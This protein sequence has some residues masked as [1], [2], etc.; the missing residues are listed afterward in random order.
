MDIAGFWVLAEDVRRL[1]ERTAKPFVDA[2]DRLAGE[3]GKGHRE[4]NE[5]MGKIRNRASPRT[6]ERALERIDE[7]LGLS[8][9]ASAANIDILVKINRAIRERN[10]VARHDAATGLRS[11]KWGMRLVLGGFFLQA[12]SYWPT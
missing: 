3:L 11:S 6:I 1:Q 7:A 2:F 9:A 5:R 12:L 8:L 10:L 4:L